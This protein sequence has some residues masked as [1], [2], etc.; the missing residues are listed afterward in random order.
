MAAIKSRTLKWHCLSSG[1]AL[2]LADNVGERLARTLAGKPTTKPGA[3][4]P[5]PPLVLQPSPPCLPSQPGLCFRPLN[6]T[7][8]QLV[9]MGQ[10]AD[11]PA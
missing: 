11:E 6:R 4:N 9:I 7:E 10:F 3:A 2:A 8:V 1:L 5:S